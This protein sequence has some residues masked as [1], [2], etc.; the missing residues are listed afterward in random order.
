MDTELI[1][2]GPGTCNT[3]CTDIHYTLYCTDI[4]V[5]CITK[6]HTILYY[7]YVV[8]THYWM[9]ICSELISLFQEN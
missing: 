8:M 7:M 4:H 1:T 9:N 6:I 5:V 3:T 2:G